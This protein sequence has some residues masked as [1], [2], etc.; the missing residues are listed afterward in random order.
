MFVENA[1]IA[2]ALAHMWLSQRGGSEANDFVYLSVADGVGTG[3][4]SN[5]QVMR[6]TRDTAG[7]FG[8]I[9]L[10][11]DGPRCHCGG[12]G[13]LEVYVSDLA[14]VVRYLGEEF[15]PTTARALVQASGLTVS[16]VVRR[17]NEGDPRAI[18]AVEATGRYL[19]AGLAVIVNAV[20]PAKI[21]VGGDIVGAWRVIEPLLTRTIRE[22]ALTDTAAATPVTHDEGGS[23]ARLRG[24]IALVAAPRFAAPSIA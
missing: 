5:G 10:S 15:S 1:P 14:T 20:S 22:R 12:R 8:H 7:E 18:A 17:C 11:A 3:I 21:C 6:G 24:A 23:Q 4:V 13:C 19:G 16:D 2:C 9:P